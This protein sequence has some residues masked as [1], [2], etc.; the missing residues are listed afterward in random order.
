MPFADL[1]RAAVEK[2]Q[3]KKRELA[4]F[5][6]LTAG[7]AKRRLSSSEELRRARVTGRP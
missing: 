1:M 7:R 3:L 4:L 2:A 5:R 6:E